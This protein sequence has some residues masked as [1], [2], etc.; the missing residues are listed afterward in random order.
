MPAYASITAT[1]SAVAE[2]TEPFA[3]AVAAP[4]AVTWPN[5]PKRTFAMERFIARLISIVSSVP[6]APT[7]M[8]LTISTLFESSNPVAAAASPVKAFRSEITTGMSAPPIG[9]TNRTPKSSAP[10]TSAQRS[11]PCSAPA[12]IATPAATHAP[13]SA[14]FTSF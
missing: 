10:P 6:D 13:S 12:R 9:S 11:Q 2:R 7:S 4:P 5:A 14:A 8:P 1:S 3:A